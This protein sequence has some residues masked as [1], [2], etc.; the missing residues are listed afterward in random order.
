MYHINIINIHHKQYYNVISIKEIHYIIIEHYSICPSLKVSITQIAQ[1][2]PLTNQSQHRSIITDHY[3][4]P[5]NFHCR[6]LLI[7]MISSFPTSSSSIPSNR[8]N[9]NTK[10]YEYHHLSQSSKI[11]P[12][13]F[14]LTQPITTYWH[15]Y[16]T[17]NVLR[18]PMITFSK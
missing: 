17:N 15:H 6:R 14:T 11:N 16:C 10:P 1:L 18:T 4:T 3:H 7:S 13:T 8:I 12:P 5:L 9:Y 2:I